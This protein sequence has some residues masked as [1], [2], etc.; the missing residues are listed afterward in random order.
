M[1]NQ[2]VVALGLQT[3]LVTTYDSTKTTL[4]GR[5]IT[6]HTITDG[7]GSKTVI[8]PSP[9]TSADVF[10][11]TGV[12]PAAI[13]CATSNGRVFVGQGVATNVWTIAYYT[14]SLT[15][16]ADVWQGSIKLT[17]GAA[18]AT[19]TI[20][21]FYV[22]DTSSSAMKI[23]LCATH[24]T[25]TNGGLFGVWG[26]NVTDFVKVSIPTFPNATLANQTK[27]VYQLGDN[28]SQASQT[29]TVADGVGVD[30]SG[31]FAYVLNGVVATPSIF[32]FSIT[33]P[34][35]A[36]PAANGYDSTLFSLKTGT[37]TGLAGTILLVN[38][39]QVI[40][41]VAQ[42]APNTGNNGSV[43]ISILTNSGIYWAKVSDITSAVTSLPS[44][45][46]ANY[47]DNSGSLI[48]TASMGQYSAFIDKW[49]IFTSLGAL[50]IKQGINNDPNAKYLGETGVYIKTEA[51][52]TLQTEWTSVTTA[53]V[54]DC[55]GWLLQLNTSVG[56]RG[57]VGIDLSCD[58]TSVNPSTSQKYS[59]IISPV[60]SNINITQGIMMGIY[61]ELAKRSV[62]ASVQ[63]RTS[64]FSTGPGAGFDATWTSVP[65]DGDLS[66]IVNQTQVQFRILFTMLNFL[67][68]NTPQINEAYFV[69]ND[70][71]QSSNNWEGSV[72][73]TTQNGVSPSYT[74]FRLKQAYATSV[75]TLYF[76]A[77]DDSGNLVVSA[78]TSSNPTLFQYTTNNGTSW[79]NLGTIPN[80]TLT[81]EVRYLWATPPGV[82][83]NPSIRES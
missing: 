40:T 68:A 73:N 37:L 41:P 36:V 8:G 9:V 4:Q 51:G 75:P 15:S 57:Y 56:Q 17:L 55:A 63:Y 47:G 28:A 69:Y 72:N 50:L 70:L 42:P 43:C 7:N 83:V 45:L 5:G 74:A 35:A 80:T 54:V 44:L 3:A 67:G 2:S 33:N 78:N 77:Y 82:N 65:I 60:I 21:G 30:V 79:I 62:K 32:K 22:D 81:T 61:Y 49:C 64:N 59:S 66:T 18:A 25:L 19:Y 31:G 27:V 48:P 1:A 46:T 29:L 34:P 39:V 52:A 10:D 12:A 23:Y 13:M 24:T 71:T 14:K 20:K 6:Q 38:N 76:R 58:E 16:G 26:V 11:D 53:C